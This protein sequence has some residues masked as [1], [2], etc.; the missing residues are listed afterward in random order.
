M[1][2]AGGTWAAQRS[3]VCP[4]T[5]KPCA[6]E[7]ALRGSW[8]SGHRHRRPD[9][10]AGSLTSDS[11]RLRHSPLCAEEGPRLQQDKSF[12]SVLFLP[13]PAEPG[14]PRH[15]HPAGM[16]THQAVILWRAQEGVCL[17]K[18]T[19]DILMMPFSGRR[20]LPC[21]TQIHQWNEG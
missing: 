13:V 21:F 11:T 10:A 8:H 3:P 7:T 12:F 16:G 4:S 15:T 5:K 17:Q 20:L 14:A 1:G 18:S 19:P 6:A 9:L 2:R